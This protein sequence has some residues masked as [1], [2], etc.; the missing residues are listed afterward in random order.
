VHL[1]F[2]HPS[3]ATNGLRVLPL[4]RQLCRRVGRF[5]R[6]Q[7]TRDGYSVSATGLSTRCDEQAC[8]LKEA[9]LRHRSAATPAT[10]ARGSTCRIPSA[11]DRSCSMSTIRLMTPR[12]A[13]EAWRD[14]G[15]GC[16][17]TF[18]PATV[19]WAARKPGSAGIGLRQSLGH[20]LWVSAERGA[21]RR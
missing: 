13:P 12:S 1:R 3:C 20:L 19:Y 14:R 15:E 21:R 16:R 10:S 17:G 2:L 5:E 18:G 8:L 6:L 11:P 4:P 9:S 7:S